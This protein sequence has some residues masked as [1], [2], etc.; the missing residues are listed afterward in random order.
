MQQIPLCF[1]GCLPVQNLHAVQTFVILNYSF[2]CRNTPVAPGRCRHECVCSSEWDQRLE[3]AQAQEGLLSWLLPWWG[4]QQ[5]RVH[6]DEC[7]SH[8][9]WHMQPKQL[10]QVILFKTVIKPRR[11]STS[12][13]LL[14]ELVQLHKMCWLLGTDLSLH[15]FSMRRSCGNVNADAAHLS[16]LFQ[17]CLKPSSW[18]NA[19]LRP[20]FNSLTNDSP[21][22]LTIWTWFS[23]TV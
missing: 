6:Q 3:S 4:G 20:T 19:G 16:P 8:S 22:S 11:S 10:S 9:C 13:L 5:R 1:N 23:V 17:Q 2:H 14:T 18:W 21:F 15:L 12:I 7:W